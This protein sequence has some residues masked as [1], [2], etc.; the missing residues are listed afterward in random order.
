MAANGLNYENRFPVKLCD[1]INNVP[2]MVGRFMCTHKETHLKYLHYI[3]FPLMKF[4]VITML[5][6]IP[7]ISRVYDEDY[8]W[9]ISI[10]LINALISIGISLYFRYIII[11]LLMTLYDLIL[12]S[13]GY[14]IMRTVSDKYD[15]WGILI[16]FG[17][18]MGSFLLGGL[19]QYTWHKIIQGRFPG[20]TPPDFIPR[21]LDNIMRLWYG[22]Y[23]VTLA[24]IYSNS[25][26]I[27]DRDASFAKY[28]EGFYAPYVF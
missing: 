6:T 20:K 5:Y 14:F 3:S 9:V 8:S 21:W 26:T 27:N 25:C 17:I 24:I 7:T 4:G 28:V 22:I 13:L 19:L 15:V 16:I 2:F 10:V 18:G 23:F 11:G 1:A 12:T